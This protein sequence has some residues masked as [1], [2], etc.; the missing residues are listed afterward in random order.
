MEVREES[1]SMINQSKRKRRKSL[2]T[3]FSAHYVM[4][5]EGAEYSA[6]NKRA[7]F[8]FLWN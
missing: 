2:K 4:Y 3:I 1:L 8:L 6:M 5:C 7:Y